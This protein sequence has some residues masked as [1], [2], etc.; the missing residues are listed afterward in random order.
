MSRISAHVITLSTVA[1]LCGLAQPA[2]AFE[3]YKMQ[4]TPKTDGVMFGTYPRAG[5]VGPV[6]VLQDVGMFPMQR[7]SWDR[8]SWIETSPG[9]YDWNQAE[10]DILLESH[11]FG[12]EAVGSVYMADKIPSFYPQDINDPVT[13]QAAATFIKAYYLE[14][15]RLLGKIWVVIDYEMQWYVFAVKGIDPDDWADW[16]VFLVNEVKSVIPDAPVICDVI[17]DGHSYYLPGAWLTAAMGVSDAMGIDDYGGTPQVIHDDIQWMID[18]YGDGKPVY[19]LENGFSTWTG[20]SNKAH[21]TEEEQALYFQSVIDDVMGSF[22]PQVKSYLQFM[23]PDAGT[24]DDIEAHWGLVTYNNGREKPALDVFR[25]AYADYPPYDVSLVRDIKDDLDGGL[26]ETFTWSAGTEFEF[27]EVTQVLDVTTVVNATLNLSFTNEDG[28]P[29]F[30]VE[31]NG[32]WKYASSAAVNVSDYLIHGVNV[33]NV[34]F[35]QERWPGQAT[36]TG[37]DLVLDTSSDPVKDTFEVY[38]DD[39]DLTT[40]WSPYLNVFPWLY[41]DG[42]PLAYAGEKSMALSYLCSIPPYFGSVTHTFS[43]AE[44]WTSFVGFGFYLKGQ[45]KNKDEKVRATLKDASGGSILAWQFFG[46]TSNS[47]WTPCE[48]YFA[49]ALDEQDMWKLAGVKQV[50][51][52]VIGQSRSSGTV[53]VDN[54]FCLSRAD[55]FPPLLLSAGP[56]NP[57]AL[58]VQF[59]EPVT[60]ES[61]QN[62]ANYLITDDSQVELPILSAAG[63]NDQRTAMITTAPQQAK[64]YKLHVQGIED[65]NGNLMKAGLADTVTFRGDDTA[66]TGVG[67]GRGG[68]RGIWMEATP[69]PFRNSL[70]IDFGYAEDAFG[71]AAVPVTVEVFDVAGR[72][73]R[74]IADGAPATGPTRYV[75]NGRNDAGRKLSA[76]VYLLRLQAGDAILA[77][78]I[79]LVR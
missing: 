75:W 14:M 45:P 26:S 72:L 41:S 74:T 66:T 50:E 28:T 21:G 19:I 55:T 37:V 77:K 10:F 46:V 6:T 18:N 17:A 24:G 20:L 7:V 30:I 39:A 43:P 8:W 56:V 40:S 51:I 47:G 76:G 23:Y 27:L 54:L 62:E 34:Y 63:I 57:T 4:A 12:A 52:A 5:S 33:F 29:N 3:V 44:D 35:P 22:R 11:K 16:Y 64:P 31:A 25:A 2:G 60:T 1:L 53:Y 13:R 58:V 9:V 69:S 42:S 70:S 61:I 32:N 68:D 38:V 49:D 59:T 73:V 67:D 79:V 36:V 71:G 15:Q 78:Q 48:I 65:L